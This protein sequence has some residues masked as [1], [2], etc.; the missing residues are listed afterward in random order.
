ME[1]VILCGAAAVIIC[2][3]V[4][5]FSSPIKK[6]FRLIAGVIT[7][8]AAL[9]LFNHAAAG[10]GISLGLNLFNSAVIGIFGPAGLAMLLFLRW[11]GL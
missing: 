1:R 8:S 3:A 7:G 4:M 2:V 6:L 9:W 5:A 10:A 11:T